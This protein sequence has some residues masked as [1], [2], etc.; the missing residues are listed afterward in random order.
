MN[1]T[2][3]ASPLKFRGGALRALL[4]HAPALL[5]A[6]LL[7]RYLPALTPPPY[8]VW[9][10]WAAEGVLAGLFAV[11]LRCAPWW[12]GINALFPVALVLALGVFDALGLSPVWLGLIFLILL[13]VFWNARGERVPLY[14]TNATTHAALREILDREPGEHRRVIDLGSGLGG[15]LQA[16]AEAPRVGEAVGVEN[17]PLPWLVS[18]LRFLRHPNIRIR[19]VS[20][21]SERLSD[22]DVIY[23]FLSPEPMPRLWAKLVREARRPMLLI[24][25]SF[26]V[27]DVEPDEIIELDDARH[28]ELFLYRLPLK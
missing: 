22:F 1:E 24:S 21:W 14:L 25:N 19:R 16:M 7:W 26:A 18:K 20:L 3:P 6:L 28:T 4:A 8:S 5:L 17:A 12:W 10:F 11:A 23:A 2:S 15:A 27:P 9:T 13:M